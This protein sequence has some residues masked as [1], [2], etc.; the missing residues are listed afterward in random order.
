MQLDSVEAITYAIR[1]ATRIEGSLLIGD[2]E[3]GADIMGTHL[4]GFAVDTITENLIIN[5]T[6]L[7]SLD[8]FNFA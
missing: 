6:K 8:A 1:N 7:R 2:G 5:L 4:A 3:A